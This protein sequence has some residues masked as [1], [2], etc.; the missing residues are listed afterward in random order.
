M[1]AYDSVV[2]QIESYDSVVA[3]IESVKAAAI[4]RQSSQSRPRPDELASL[5]LEQLAPSP[6]TRSRRRLTIAA[7]VIAAIVVP[8]VLPPILINALLQHLLI[9]P[10]M[11][12]VP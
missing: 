10:P 9:P 3:Q 5:T 11:P 6:T 12:A 2:A 1:Q 8:L 7:A 4:V